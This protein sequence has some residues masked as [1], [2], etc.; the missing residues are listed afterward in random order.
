MAAKLPPGVT[1]LTEEEASV[2]LPPGV[3]PMPAGRGIALPEAQLPL[4]GD[5]PFL[6]PFSTQAPPPEAMAAVAPMVTGAAGTAAGG[7]VGGLPGMMAGSA[8][9]EGVNQAVGLTPPS[10]ENIAVAGAV[11]AMASGAGAAINRGAQWLAPKLPGAAAALHDI[12]AA[13]LE[14][15]KGA[16]AP[17]ASADDLYA[18]VNQFNPRVPLAQTAAAAKALLSREQV[19]AA[20]LKLP[21]VARTAAAIERQGASRTV[22][23]GLVDVQG[24][25]ITRTVRGTDE[26]S[27][28]DIRVNLRRIGDKV[29]E[30]RASGGEEHGAWKKLYQSVM[31]DLEAAATAGNPAMPA[32]AA[33]KAANA[34]ARREFVADEIADILTAGIRLRSDN[35]IQ[36]NFGRILNKLRESEDIVKTLKPEEF[37][38]LMAKVGEWAKVTPAMPAVAGVDAGSKR[39]MGAALAAGGLVGGPATWAFGPTVGAAMG[40]TAMGTAA[41]AASTLSRAMMSESGRAFLTRL[42]LESGGVLDPRTLALLS[43]AVSQ[44]EPTRTG[45]QGGATQLGDLFMQSLRGTE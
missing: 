9:A 33:L 28:Q 10:A 15:L 25:V 29:R 23:T 18:V 21:G 3:T 40:A 22:E 38:A 7:A 13:G 6:L 14:R 5:L 20:G 31:A 35:L 32:V 36:V 16:F 1:P 27:F 42:L 2:L 12:A 19:A 24:K 43:V 39:V 30:T 34:A 44:T 26:M 4:V 41:A 17:S 11:P 8:A 37:K 45:L